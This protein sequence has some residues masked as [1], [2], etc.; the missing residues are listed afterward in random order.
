MSTLQNHTFEC[1]MY[2]SGRDLIKQ[3]LPAEP[4]PMRVARLRALEYDELVDP[5]F[6][7]LLAAFNTITFAH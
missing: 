5:R 4:G 1:H 6:R 7:R 3:K 2:I